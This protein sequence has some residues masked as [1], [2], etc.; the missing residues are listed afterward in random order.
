[1]SFYIYIIILLALVSTLGYFRGRA[2]N[3]WIGGW[4]AAGTEEIL[5]P[6]D[7]NYTNIGGTIG[8]NFVYKLKNPFTEAKGTFTL[9]PRQSILY[10]PISRLIARYDRFYMNIFLQGKLLGEGHIVS[11]DYYRRMRVPIVGESRLKKDRITLG[12]REYLLF[13]D[14]PSLKETLRN[15]VL[16][17]EER[18]GLKHFCCYKDNNTLFI[19][20]TVRDREMFKKELSRFYSSIPDF[21]AKGAKKNGDRAGH[22]E[23]GDDKQD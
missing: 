9:L 16:S 1:M 12:N 8:Y 13:W 11:S 17:Q 6:R 20:L 19:Y 23:P 22:T 21:M 5:K 4:I 14:N 18:A 3:R 7:T 10:Y 15:Y 2:R